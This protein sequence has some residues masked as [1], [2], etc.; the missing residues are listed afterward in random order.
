MAAYEA[1]RP[2]SEAILVDRPVTRRA[3]FIVLVLAAI[4]LIFAVLFAFCLMQSNPGASSWTW[5]SGITTSALI[6]IITGLGL[7]FARLYSERYVVT[8][9]AIEIT[10]GILRRDSRKIPLSNVLDVTSNSSF[11]RRLFGVGN[12]TVAIANGD[13]ITLEDVS[14]PQGKA[15]TL[16][17]LVHKK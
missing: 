5:A 14:D 4:T 7:D 17:H 10:S 16:W 13:R 6:I 1:R 2:H 8:A 9:D 3:A 12:I 15:E 11:D